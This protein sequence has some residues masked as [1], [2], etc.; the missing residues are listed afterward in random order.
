M[1]SEILLTIGAIAAVDRF[2]LRRKKIKLEG[3]GSHQARKKDYLFPIIFSTYSTRIRGAQ[4]E[5]QLK[6][7]NNPTTV[8]TGK[9]RTLEFSHKGLNSEFLSIPK[10]LISS[11]GDWVLHVKITHGD[12]LWNPF[13]RVFPIVSKSQKRYHL[14]TPKEEACKC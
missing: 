1:I 5:Y 8:I 13:Y 4:V 12:S 6:D 2:A 11:E 14:E 7:A 10:C 9:T 3:I